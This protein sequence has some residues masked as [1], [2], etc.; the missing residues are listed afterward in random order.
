MRSYTKP[1]R[2]DKTGHPTRKPVKPPYFWLI[3]Q[4]YLKSSIRRFQGALM[5]CSKPIRSHVIAVFMS[6]IQHFFMI[7]VW[8]NL[9][10]FW[11]PKTALVQEPTDL[12]HRMKAPWNRLTEFYT[13]FRF[14]SQKYGGFTNFRVGWPVLSTLTGFVYDRIFTLPYLKKNFNFC[15]REEKNQKSRKKC[16]KLLAK[17]R[18]NIG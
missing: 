5:R 17:V 9:R 18:E 10:W 12:E 15:S 1:V 7:L 8:V 4:K 14:L 6:K 3:N 16:A 2:V 11:A 13:F